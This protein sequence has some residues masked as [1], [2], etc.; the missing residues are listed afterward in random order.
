MRNF[1]LLLRRFWNLIL[2]VFL[3]F[4][5]IYL[6]AKNKK[7]Q[8]LTIISSSNKIV[9]YLYKKQSDI[10]QYFQLK[11]LNDELI[12][13]HSYLLQRIS[14]YEATDSFQNVLAQ[15]PDTIL[16]E[17]PQEFDTLY[18]KTEA[19]E[20]TIILKPITTEK[21]VITYTDYEFVPVRV[22]KNSI[23]QS[24]INFITLNRGKSSGIKVGMPVVLT[25]GIVGRVAQVSEN[26]A[27]VASVLSNR[28]IH[29]RIE[30]DLPGFLYWDGKDPAYVRMDDLSLIDSIS[31]GE[32]VYTTEDS[33][34]PAN[35]EIGEVAQ[36]EK[37]ERTNSK[38]IRIKLNT[39]FRNLKYAYVVIDSKVEEKEKLEEKTEK[40]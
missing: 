19:G 29:A 5:S 38:S 11:Q 24:H 1:I 13:D 31:I 32:K 40:N 17:K 30:N 33:Y 18:D 20:D 8:G 26:F 10:I 12:A 35:I 34:F 3:L 23:T 22:I 36:V 9:G 2:F 14:N 4:V 21:I 6:I 15:L 37:I 7:M 28:K 16:S 27:T 39:N 25:N